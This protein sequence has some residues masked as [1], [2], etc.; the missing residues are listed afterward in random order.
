MTANYYLIVKYSNL[1][2]LIS[3]LFANNISKVLTYQRQLL[4]R[5]LQSI[6]LKNSA[7]FKGKH[8]C[9]SLFL[10]Q[11]HASSLQLFSKRD[12]GWILR[13][14]QEHLFVKHLRA[15][16]SVIHV[17]VHSSIWITTF[18]SFFLMHPVLQLSCCFK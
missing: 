17:L 2:Q 6:C 1:L 16:A 18:K 10:I 3:C 13:I 15:T 9:W 14:F 4:A 12:S 8:L 7:K 11:L 5:I